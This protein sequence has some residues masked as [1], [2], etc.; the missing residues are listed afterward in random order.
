MKSRSI[1][2]LLTSILFTSCAPVPVTTMEAPV[3]VPTSTDVVVLQRIAPELERV[4][5][6]FP[7]KLSLTCNDDICELMYQ[8]D[9]S[10]PPAVVAKANALPSNALLL[11]PWLYMINVGDKEVR[12][13]E[14]S[15]TWIPETGVVTLDAEGS[16]YY[17]DSKTIQGWKE[18]PD[19]LAMMDGKVRQWD[20]AK[21]QFVEVEVSATVKM[22][23]NWRLEENE[24]D[25]LILGGDGIKFIWDSE[26]N[27]FEQVFTHWSQLPGVDRENPNIK[28][29]MDGKLEKILFGEG[30]HVWGLRGWGSTDS[31]EVAIEAAGIKDVGADAGI[32]S[33][34]FN[35]ELG[36]VEFNG[37]E[38]LMA[39]G[40]VFDWGKILE[41]AVPVA[42]RKDGEFSVFFLPVKKN[43]SKYQVGKVNSFEDYRKYW[44][45]QVDADGFV[46]TYF[47]MGY[48]EENE[49]GRPSEDGYMAWLD[50]EFK[51]LSDY[52]GADA[53][54]GYRHDVVREFV[55]VLTVSGQYDRPEYWGERR[56]EKMMDK[57]P[58]GIIAL[59][60]GV[61][62][63]IEK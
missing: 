41:L 6:Q 59:L 3:I 57:S 35:S 19:G 12:Y 34:I 37:F 7:E 28:E 30:Q 48:V 36:V 5:Q 42:I 51:S 50:Y 11:N 16:I 29:L 61:T 31:V 10:T 45:Q 55:K 54:W 21:K 24:T 1:V 53:G 46:R 2:I 33:A 8:L 52:A 47:H 27:R 60:E 44:A 62:L 38:V 26:A 9:D 18:L 43:G 63:V 22:D 49:G 23:G 40:L 56:V 58:I 32:G 4:A 17:F 15:F 25:V 39:R 14:R 20:K 13:L